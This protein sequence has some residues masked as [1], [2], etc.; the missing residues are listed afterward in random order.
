MSHFS[1]LVV[2]DEEPNKKMIADIMEPYVEAFDPEESEYVKQ[3]DETESLTEEYHSNY[4][5]SVFILNGDK[6]EFFSI[7]YSDKINEFKV[8]GKLNLPDNY[9]L[10]DALASDIMTLSEYATEFHNYLEIEGRFYSYQNPNA[11]WDWYVVGGRWSGFFKPKK[12]LKKGFSLGEESFFQNK[13]A[14]G[15][16]DIIQKEAI[17]IDSMVEDK[18]NE[19][20]NLWS[21]YE[22]HIGNGKVKSW[23]NCIEEVKLVKG[24]NYNR[25]DILEI[26]QN[27]PLH[28]ELNELGKELNIF[29]CPADFFREGDKELFMS[30]KK[31]EAL[32]TFAIIHDKKWYQKG[33]MGWFGQYSDGDDSWEKNYLNFFDNLPESSWLTIVDCHI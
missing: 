28:N 26:Y 17:D 18:I 7:K 31:Y 21:F 25:E 9:I 2:T 16:A 13:A 5:P 19:A 15:R 30:T 11:K 12:G 3:I 4:I 6:K 14:K 33:E 23:K 1:V 24:D 10:E 8:N 29:G 20:E 22:K 27:Q 32:G